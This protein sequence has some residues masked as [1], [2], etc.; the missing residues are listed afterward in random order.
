MAPATPHTAAA[1]PKAKPPALM[2][3]QSTRSQMLNE[4]NVQQKKAAVGK[5]TPDWRQRAHRLLEMPQSSLA[6]TVIFVLLISAIGV[7]VLL[8]FLSSISTEVDDS[9]EMHIAETVCTLIFTIELLVR[10]AVATTDIRNLLLKDITF[11]V[12][13]ISI[14]PYY[15]E[16]AI[17]LTSSDGS[18]QVPRALKGLQ[19]CRLARILKLST[20]RPSLLCVPQTSPYLPYI[21]LTPSDTPPAHVPAAAAK[22]P[23]H[24]TFA[25]ITP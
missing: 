1:L 5:G 16:L 4:L 23:H 15:T 3:R 18:A 25:Y 7:S 11:W 17:R 21:P 19:L 9:A 14:V 22:R 12:D 13:F 6:A 8:Y 2:K 10:A 24:T 20:R